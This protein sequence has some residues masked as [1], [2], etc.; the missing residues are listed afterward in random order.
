MSRA[1]S[2]LN[3]SGGWRWLTESRCI[4]FAC[5]RLQGET[6][7]TTSCLDSTYPGSCVDYNTHLGTGERVQQDTKHQW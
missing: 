2:M 1:H 5:W 7:I 4:L 3:P 6:A